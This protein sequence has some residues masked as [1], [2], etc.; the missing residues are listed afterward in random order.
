M[1]ESFAHLAGRGFEPARLTA[2]HHQ[3]LAAGAQMMGAGLW[4]RPAYYGP[5]DGRDAAIAAEVRA[6]REGVGLIDVGTLGKL[7]IRGPDAAAFLERIYAGAY[8]KQPVGRTRYALA[9]DMTGAII[10]DGVAC[11]LAEDWFYV[12]ATTS[13]VDTLYRAML[14]WNAEWRL[15]VDIANVTAAYAAV[16]IAGPLARQVLQRL[17]GDVD[18]AARALPLPRRA[19]GY[20]GRRAGAPAPGRLRRR[21][22][23]RDPLPGQL[24]RRPVGA[25]G[26]C[27]RRFRPAPVRRRGAADLRLEKGHLIVGQDTDGLTFPHEAGMEWAIGR[28]KP[29]FIGNRAIRVQS[30][31][32]LTRR[33]VGFTLPLDAP[34][35]PE[36]CLVIRGGAI[37]GRVTSAA[38]SL[39]C[40]VIVGLAYVHPDDA[41]PGRRFT[42]KLED[43]SLVE[44]TVV[45]LPFYDPDGR[46]QEL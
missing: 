7:E 35:P 3:H 15:A 34:L 2:M 4:Y 39:A 27:R 36:C 40:G 20:A 29:F 8:A 6:V 30:A 26:R 11:R 17:P 37:V 28:Q 19:R 38:R 25:A 1:P 14:R 16:N 45:P 32:P 10:D 44:P 22:R 43:G 33:L 41:T 12:T 23:L 13:G 18:L 5:K 9:C 21:A 42:V 31:R 46:R 24:R